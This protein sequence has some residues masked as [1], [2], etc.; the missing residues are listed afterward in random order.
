MNFAVYEFTAYDPEA[1]IDYTF[2]GYLF[3]TGEVM[4]PC[5]DT[6]DEFYESLDTAEAHGA[7]E[8]LKYAPKGEDY[9]F[10]DKEIRDAIIGSASEFGHY[11]IPDTLRSWLQP[12]EEAWRAPNT[13]T[14]ELYP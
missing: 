3:P 4:I 9:L 8:I 14:H 13:R 2:H 7:D 12:D 11:A 10:S 5:A 1:D 6:H